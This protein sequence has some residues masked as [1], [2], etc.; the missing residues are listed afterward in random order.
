M[1]TTRG[2]RGLIA[3]LNENGPWGGRNGG[4]SGG[5]GGDDGGKGG[6]K[7]GGGGPR[8]PWSFPPSGGGK[9]GRGPSALDQL[10][11]QAKGKFG[12]D[13]PTGT[14]KL[15]SYAALGLLIAWIGFTTIHFIDPQERGVVTRLGKYS[16][17]LDP[18]MTF[19]LPAPIDR[20]QTVDVQNIRNVDIPSG[21]GEKLVL[22]RDENIIDL[23]YSIRWN[24]KDPELYLFQL[25]EPEQT[26]EA[27]AESAMRAAIAN[28]SLNDAIGSGRT[29][30]ETEVTQR[31]QALLDKYRS[32]VKIQGIAIKRADPP[33]AVNEAFKKVSA[34]Q[35]K[36]QTDVN[37]ANAYAQQIVAKAG[38]EAAAF[39]R[40]YVQ[41]KASPEVTRRRMYYE[42]MERVLAKVDK[43]IV[44]PGVT[45]YLPLQ[46]ARSAP[47]AVQQGAGQ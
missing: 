45:P 25:A 8:N 13:L 20:V 16:H 5:G 7:G 41:Y 9:G 3:L 11:G 18:G 22:T 10:F 44:E 23:D 47:P 24:I 37:Q 34:A 19:T 4:P 21:A 39:D 26:I 32:G 35:Q 17:T 31:M 42:T 33:E 28:V 40:V 43:T 30:I 1:E 12:G 14:P 15:W 6:G 2:L 38:G 36:A 46:G 27:V 29:G